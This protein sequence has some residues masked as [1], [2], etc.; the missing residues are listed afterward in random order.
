MQPDN[1]VEMISWW[2]ALEFANRLSE[3][4]GLIP[5]YDMSGMEFE[6][7]AAQGTLEPTSGELKI[8]SPDGDFYHASGYRLPT[9]AE[10]EY[11]ARGGT[12]TT[13]SFGDSEA[14]LGKYAWWDG[15]SE[16]HTHPVALKRKNPYKLYDMHG[17]VREWAQDWHGRLPGGIDP[18]RSSSGSNRVI[19]GGSWN[20]NAQYLRSA[21]RYS[22]G[23]GFRYFNVGFRLVRTL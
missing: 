15:N 7:S 22:G 5:V 19:R 12:S 18:L 2:S 16:G 21:N 23:A 1:P 4:R 9:E 14:E 17:N 6:G 8:N 11:A 20:Y 13:Y 3:E 10:W